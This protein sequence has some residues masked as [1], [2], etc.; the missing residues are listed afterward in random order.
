M[1]FELFDSKKHPIDE[2]ANIIYDI[3]FRTYEMFYKNKKSTIKDISKLLLKDDYSENFYVIKIKDEVVGIIT[4][5]VNEG[6]SHIDLFKS[7]IPLRLFIIYF[8]QYSVVN[9]VNP[10][11]I[12]IT[13]LGISSKCRGK[14]IGS[15]VINEVLAYGRQNNFKKSYIGCRF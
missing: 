13:E 12:H 3:D 14:G 6:H 8:M 1:K 15:K 5:W 4:F 7:F 11:D 10:G 2:I 9:D